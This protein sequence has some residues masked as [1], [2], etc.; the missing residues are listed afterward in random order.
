MNNNILAEIALALGAYG[1]IDMRICDRALRA[2]CNL[3]HDSDNRT[4]FGDA[5]CCEGYYPLSTLRFSLPLAGYLWLQALPSD[6]RQRYSSLSLD[7]YL[8]SLLL[9]LLLLVVVVVVVVLLIFMSE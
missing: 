5:G 1:T 9:L 6:S 2:I 4:R 3:A 8:L 7:S